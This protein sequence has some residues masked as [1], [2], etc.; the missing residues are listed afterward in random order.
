M[1]NHSDPALRTLGSPKNK[2]MMCNGCPG[3]QDLH[4]VDVQ[5]KSDALGRLSDEIEGAWRITK[6]CDL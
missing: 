5:N 3:T 1:I 2:S 4:A 6:L